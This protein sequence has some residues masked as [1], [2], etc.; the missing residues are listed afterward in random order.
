[1]KIVI[2]GAKGQ[3]GS[4]LVEQALHAGLEVQA[5]SSQALDITQDLTLDL[6]GVDALINCAAYTAVDQAEDAPE[7]AFA[8]NATGVKNLAI[9]CKKYQV[10]LI[11]LSTD[12]VFDGTKKGAYFETDPPNP[13]NVYGA[14]K[15]KGEQLLQATWEKHIILRVSWVFGRFG[16]NFVKTIL[17]LSQERPQLKIV[18]DQIGSPTAAQHISQ[19]ILTLLRHP[20]LQSNWG[21]YHY[22]D[23]PLTN[24][25]DFAKNFVNPKQCEITPIKTAE[26]LTKAKRPQNSAL[27]CSKINHVFGIKQMEW[28]TAL[29]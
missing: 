10:P 1:M 20:K 8:V 28:K 29:K 21:I 12:Y 18:S 11:H 2:T 7:K 6:S 16:N 15:L 17:R 14:S 23:A 19:L 24:W 25:C 13:Q 26:Y 5:Y 3:L 27:N 22:T 9:L 4:E